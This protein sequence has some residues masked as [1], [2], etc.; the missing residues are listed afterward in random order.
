MAKNSNSNVAKK[1][2][3]IG[4]AAVGSAGMAL[5]ANAVYHGMTEGGEET[6]E[7]VDDEL[8][9][10]ENVE[11]EYDEVEFESEAPA[12]NYTVVPAVDPD[13]IVEGADI[14]EVAL[15]VDEPDIIAGMPEG[16][17]EVAIEVAVAE[18]EDFNIDDVVDDILTDDTTQLTYSEPTDDH[19]FGADFDYS[20]TDL[21]G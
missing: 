14:N 9:I 5:G 16:E 7:V 18:E 11:V 6:E 13:P 17:T 2:G 19:G 4:G 15:E 10:E 1:V 20:S 8:E 3:I 21:L 12:A